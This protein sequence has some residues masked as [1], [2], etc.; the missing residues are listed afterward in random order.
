[1]SWRRRCFG[2]AGS[3]WHSAF[4]QRFGIRGTA[5]SSTRQAAEKRGQRFGKSTRRAGDTDNTIT[6]A[7]DAQRWRAVR[8]QRAA[9]E[10]LIAPA[11]KF[12]PPAFKDADHVFG[13]EK[14]G[15][16]GN[17]PLTTST[18]RATLGTF[19]FP[20]VLPAPPVARRRG[21]WFSANVRAD[22]DAGGLR[23]GLLPAFRLHFLRGN[24][25]LQFANPK[26]DSA[27]NFD[28]SKLS[29]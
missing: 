14:F 18:R 6:A 25:A 8:V 17:A 2:G 24:E 20:R 12:Q 27:A 9:G 15:H 10:P 16:G 23:G 21:V 5:R 26:P 22:G 13:G 4:P 29:G 1:M 7:K 11:D 3:G 28:H 19:N